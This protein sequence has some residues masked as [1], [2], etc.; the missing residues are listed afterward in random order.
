[1]IRHRIGWTAAAAFVSLLGSAATASAQQG[2]LSISGVGYGQ[3]AYWLSDDAGYNEFALTRA[4]VNV[5]GAFDH[6][7][8]TRVTTDIYRDAN[9]SY[10][11]RLKYGFVAWKP[12]GSPVEV[13]FGQIHTPWIAWQE[14]LWGYRMQGTVP[15]DRSGLL[16]SADLGLGLSGGAADHAVD[17]EASLVNGEGYHHGEDGSHKD[18]EGRLSIRLLSTDLSGPLGG[19]RLTG[20]AGLGAPASGGVRNRF[21]GELSYK[22]TL[23]TLAGEYAVGQS[24]V[25]DVAADNLTVDARVMSVFGVLDVPDSPLSFIARV[26]A[27]DP[28]TDTEDDARTVV[29]GGV[30]YRISSNLRVLADVDHTGYQTD[31]TG[32]AERARTQGL[33]QVEFKF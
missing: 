16:T 18:V 19:L 23:L 26:D 8:S 22:S 9:G 25:G 31:P 3:Y 14:D 2:G 30:A 21:A 27:V 33:F 12:E 5:R 17:F 15:L 24:R 1:M 32:V 11:V 29:I 28:D 6:G 13:S 4:Y 10:N 7:V 20:Y